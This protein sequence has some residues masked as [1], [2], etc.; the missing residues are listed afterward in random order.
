MYLKVQTVKQKIKSYTRLLQKHYNTTVAT[1]QFSQHSQSKKH[2]TDSKS[3]L[4][5]Y[6]NIKKIKLLVSVNG[7][8][9]V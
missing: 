8:F 5:S 7:K 3:R 4:R 6:L 2:V 9:I 1:N